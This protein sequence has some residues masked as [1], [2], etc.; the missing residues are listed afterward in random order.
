MPP[1]LQR[2]VVTGIGLVTP[3]GCGVAENWDALTAGRSGI[4][5][6]DRFDASTFPVRFAGQVRGFEAERYVERKEI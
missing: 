3:L 5:L 4:G 2:V 6:I 1:S